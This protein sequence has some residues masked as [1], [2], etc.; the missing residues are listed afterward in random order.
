MGKVA[1]A[2][3]EESLLCW[4]TGLYQH[5]FHGHFSDGPCQLLFFPHSPSR[6]RPLDVL[7]HNGAVPEVGCWDF[8]RGSEH[9]SNLL[10]QLGGIGIFLR[11]FNG[12]LLSHESADSI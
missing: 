7:C 2:G 6:D 11:V 5:S 4:L 12:M 10:C 9:P 8:Q 3:E 1:L